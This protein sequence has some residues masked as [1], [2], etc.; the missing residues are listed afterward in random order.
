MGSA[1]VAG[2]VKKQICAASDILVCELVPERRDELSDRYGV[3]TTD[4]IG[5]STRFAKIILLAVKPAHLQEV[6]PRLRQLLTTQ[7]VLVSILAGQSRR[8]LAA[9]LGDSAEIVRVMP[10]LPA[11]VEA[12]ISAV[13]YGPNAT[14]EVRSAVNE[15]LSAVGPVV[16]VEENLQDAVTAVSGSGPG[17]LFYLVDQMIIAAKEAGLPD[18]VARQL[19]IR[20]FAGTGR[21][22]E[23]ASEEPGALVKRVAT[24]GGT[25]EAGLKVLSEAGLPEIIREMIRKATERSRELGQS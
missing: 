7:H 8:K 9:V 1:L 3:K 16:E 12:G 19:V 17:Y 14:E 13:T 18:G 20:T 4:G 11:Q 22:L 25:T 23:Q 24:P 21:Y 10:N 5:E 6:G 15:I 2:L